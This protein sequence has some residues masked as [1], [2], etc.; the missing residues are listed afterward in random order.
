MNWQILFTI[1]SASVGLVAGFW[2]CF[3]TAAANPHVIAWVSEPP[4]KSTEGMVSLTISQSAQ[5]SVGGLLLFVAFVFQIVAALSST[6]MIQAPCPALQSVFAFSALVVFAS[7]LLTLC[8]S[9]LGHVWRKRNLHKKVSLA[10]LHLQSN[11]RLTPW[12]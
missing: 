10:L 3:P 6:T 8:S 9:Y 12:L 11:R 4:Y 1:V 5:Y 2:L 7:L